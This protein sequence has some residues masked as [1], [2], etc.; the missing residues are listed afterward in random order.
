MSRMDYIIA[1]V[2]MQMALFVTVSVLLHSAGGKLMTNDYDMVAFFQYIWAIIGTIGLVIGLIIVT[3]RRINTVSAPQWTIVGLIFAPALAVYLSVRW[4]MDKSVDAQ[5]QDRQY[6]FNHLIDTV[7][8]IILTVI[9]CVVT[10]TYGQLSWL[11]QWVLVVIGLGVVYLF[12]RFFF[13][14]RGSI[15]RN[16]KKHGSDGFV[17]FLIEIIIIV[18]IVSFVRTLITTPYQINGPS[19][20]NGYFWWNQEWGVYIW[21]EY[22][23][24]DKISYADMFAFHVW[25]PKRGD[26]VVFTPRVD[27]KRK[28]LI[29]RVI[30]LP[31]EVLRIHDGSIWIQ[32]TEDDEFVRLDETYLNETNYNNTCESYVCTEW[33]KQKMVEY[34]IPEGWY[35]LMGDNRVQSQDSRQCFSRIL[36]SVQ[37]SARFIGRDQILWRVLLSVWHYDLFD[38]FPRLG[39]REWTYKPRWFNIPNSYTYNELDS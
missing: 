33:E 18:I 10:L 16:W 28:Y 39:K 12:S 36:C 31:G 30:G 5:D 20:N 26:V 22:I 38:W 17:Q 13:F 25:H 15:Q 21:G 3:R 1:Q 2:F 8:L 4:S 7:I 29:K 24:V 35:I 14:V 9:I 11:A 32:E 23:L 27:P 34:V 6:A 37:P 19:M